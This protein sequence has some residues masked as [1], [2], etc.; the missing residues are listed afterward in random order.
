[1]VGGTASMNE[2]MKAMAVDSMASA[3]LLSGAVTLAKIFG[4]FVAAFFAVKLGIKR[5]FFVSAVLVGVGVLTPVA[6]NYELLL[7]S[8]FIMGLGGALMVVYFNPIVLHWFSAEQRPVVNGLNAVAFNIGTAIV[9]WFMPQINQ[10]SGGWQA[11]LVAF[12]LASL[13]MAGLWL[14]VKFD[15]ADSDA[16]A[17]ASEQTPYSYRDGLRDKFNWVYAL[18]YGGLLAFYI[19][20][21]TFYPQAGISHSK[22]VIGSGIF[23]TVA[24]IM[25]CQ[26]VSLRIP[27]IRWSGLAITLSIICLTFIDNSALQLLAAMFLGFFIF[28]PMTALITLPQELPG[29]NTQRIT[30]VFSLFWSISYLFATVALWI[31][32]KLVDLNQGDFGPSFIF[33]TVLSTSLFVG[34]FWLPE[35]ANAHKQ[36]IQPQEAV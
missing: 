18:S 24:G 9:L 36:S 20:L 16:K 10:L 1:W 19:C 22:W 25:F 17:G 29:M 7:L 34:S 23:G 26:Q 21:F 12:S 33:I 11:S 14:L 30:V 8:R 27:V 32:G 15:S 35:T 3:S 4:T 28:L 6:P 2:I 31:F 13:L 5:A